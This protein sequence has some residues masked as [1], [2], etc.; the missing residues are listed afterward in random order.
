VPQRFSRRRYSACGDKHNAVCMHR[1]RIW[2]A[3]CIL[4]VIRYRLAFVLRM[5]RYSAGVARGNARVTK[6]AA[7]VKRQSGSIS[8]IEIMK[9]ISV[10]GSNEGENDGRQ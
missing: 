4:P 1:F 9:K 7:C 10:G 8:I 2:R 5:L 6:R 3:A